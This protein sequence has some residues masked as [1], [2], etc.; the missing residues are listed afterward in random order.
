MN[1]CKVRLWHFIAISILIHISIVI[2]TFVPVAIQ[3]PAPVQV[4][5]TVIEKKVAEK[6]AR[7]PPKGH[8]KGNPKSIRLSQL[9]PQIKMHSSGTM[10]V[11]P[12]VGEDVDDDTG[13]EWGSGAADFHRISDYQLMREL[14]RELDYH[15]KY[16]SL[17][18]VHGVKGVVNSRIVINRQGKC[19][20]EKSYTRSSNKYLRKYVKHQ[21]RK[22]C[23]LNLKH[24][25]R[26]KFTNVDVSVFYDSYE[27]DV[28][29]VAAVNNNIVGNVLLFYRGMPRPD[30]VSMNEPTTRGEGGPEYRVNILKIL[31]DL[32]ELSKGDKALDR[33]VD[34]LN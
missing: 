23:H 17:F 12:S 33:F 3:V 29:N 22:V 18:V 15:I 28:E 4:E 21:I 34:N 14:Y 25:V 8:T 5:V 30:Y 1:K 16:P 19:D 7:R 26:R 10:K 11:A 31:Q 24:L 27:P 32:N 20:G 2:L 9:V 13:V 6:P